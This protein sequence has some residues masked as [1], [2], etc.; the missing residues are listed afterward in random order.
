KNAS[1]ATQ[2]HPSPR[3]SP[4]RE[5]QHLYGSRP[6]PGSHQKRDRGRHQGPHRPTRQRRPLHGR[7]RT[8]PY[9]VPDVGLRHAYSYVLTELDNILESRPVKHPE[10]IPDY[11]MRLGRRDPAKAQEHMNDILTRSITLQLMAQ[12]AT[13]AMMLCQMGLP[14]VEFGS[15]I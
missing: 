14:P 4:S 11:R 3:R 9:P 12:P 13:S 5:Y 7:N 6:T 15:E 2:K 1:P 10:Q 8:S